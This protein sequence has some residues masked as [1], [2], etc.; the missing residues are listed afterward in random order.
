MHARRGEIKN[1]I[2][3]VGVDKLIIMAISGKQL[4]LKHEQSQ[5]HKS[6]TPSEPPSW[7]KCYAKV[8]EHS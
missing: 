3:W 4:P 6:A 1:P 7:Q 5:S 8:I 2:T